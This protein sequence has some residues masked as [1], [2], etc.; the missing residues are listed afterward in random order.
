MTTPII[1]L[2]LMT[3]PFLATRLSGA[4]GLRRFDDQR[5]AVLGLGFLF[6]FT[7]TGHFLQ[8]E[9]MAAMLPSDVPARILLVQITGVLEFAIAVGF[10]FPATRRHAGWAALVALILFFPANV[11]AAVNRIPMGGHAWGPIYLLVRTPLQIA[12]MA[13]IYWFVVR[14]RNDV[15]ASSGLA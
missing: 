8:T 9:P 10:F 11:Y 7:A 15:G 13:W 2:V 6:V 1:M 4:L 12:I 3:G 14:R 5:A